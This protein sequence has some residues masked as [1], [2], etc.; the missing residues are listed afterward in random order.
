M[1][2]SNDPRFFRKSVLNKRLAAFSSLS[3]VSG[4]MVG[5]TTAVISMR[6]DMSIET[7][8]GKL[9]LLSFSIM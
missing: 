5:T 3:V 2:M 7:F 1:E 4:L 9:Q 8:D 6:K